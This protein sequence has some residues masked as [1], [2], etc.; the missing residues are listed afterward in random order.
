MQHPTGTTVRVRFARVTTRLARLSLVL[1]AFASGLDGSGFGAG[2]F[3]SASVAR[4]QARNSIHYFQSSRH[5][6]GSVGQGQLLRGGPLAGYFQPVEIH[7]PPGAQI[8]LVE[9]GTFAPPEAQPVKVGMLIGQVYRLRVTNIP[10]RTGEEVYPTIE[11]INRLYPPP[12][13]ALRFPIPIVL[14]TRELHMALEGSYVTRVIYLEDPDKALP[15]AETNREQRYFELHSKEDPLQVADQMGKPMAILRIG[16][17][18]PD[19]DGPSGRFVYRTPPFQRYPEIH[20]LEEVPP[21]A[22][23]RPDEEEAPARNDVTQGQDPRTRGL[24]PLPPQIRS[25]RVPRLPS[26]TRSARVPG[27]SLRG[28]SATIPGSNP[29]GVR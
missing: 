22:P 12:G 15:L 13:Q 5:P 16:S 4:A 1:A 3:G 27:S 25:G 23:R 7:A 20:G 28:P 17:R 14:T 19:L 18:V 21:V 29:E 6:A 26:R 11:I 8:S 9:H 10:A 24:E 2:G